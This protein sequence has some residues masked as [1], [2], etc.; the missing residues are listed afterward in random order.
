MPAK[1]G[2]DHHAVGREGPVRSTRIEVFQLLD[3]I[4]DIG[5]ELAMEARFGN[6]T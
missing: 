4:G 6:P 1:L 3:P 2:F 5:V